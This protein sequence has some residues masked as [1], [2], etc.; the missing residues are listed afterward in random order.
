[1]FG[2][3][4][5]L[6]AAGADQGDLFGP[7]DD[8]GEAIAGRQGRHPLGVPQD[9]PPVTS[10]EVRGEFQKLVERDLLGP[11]DG[12]FEELP[13]KAIGPRER[14]LVGML[15]PKPSPKRVAENAGELPDTEIG[16]EGDGA[17]GECRTC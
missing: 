17:E 7:G 6:F 3:Q 4:E 13:P 2:R 14:Y 12:E 9:F 10:F 11:Y 15:G 8:A 1:M 16:A 5:K